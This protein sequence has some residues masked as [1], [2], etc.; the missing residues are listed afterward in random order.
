MFNHPHSFRLHNFPTFLVTE[1]YNISQLPLWNCFSLQKLLIFYKPNNMRISR[2]FDIFLYCLLKYEKCKTKNENIHFNWVIDAFALAVAIN[3]SDWK[4]DRSWRT[5]P[6]CSDVGHLEA[7]ENNMH[8]FQERQKLS[9]S[10]RRKK[11]AKFTIFFLRKMVLFI[12]IGIH[13]RGFKTK[14]KKSKSNK[15]RISL[16]QHYS[17]EI[18]LNMIFKQAQ[19]GM[20]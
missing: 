18:M 10:T 9:A 16:C 1:F 6:F 17:P 2:I 15:K 14:E 12:L 11:R 19:E 5:I 8:K 13:L 3:F 4:H 7:R 20:K